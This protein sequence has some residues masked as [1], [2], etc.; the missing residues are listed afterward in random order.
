MFLIRLCVWVMVLWIF[1]V[2]LFLVRFGIV[3]C[4]GDVLM[5]V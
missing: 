1:F 2:I 4:R 5:N 3:W